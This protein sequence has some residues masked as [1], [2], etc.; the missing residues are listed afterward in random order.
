MAT[1]AELKQRKDAIKLPA[2]TGWRTVAFLHDQRGFPAS[3]LVCP[4]LYAARPTREPDLTLAG[5]PPGGPLGGLGSRADKASRISSIVTGC[6]PGS[7]R[8]AGLDATR[9][10]TRPRRR[11]WRVSR[12][13]K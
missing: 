11:G 2:A 1:I 8:N 9:R 7:S 10:H 5:L 4:A 3:K 6:E 13:L 12:R